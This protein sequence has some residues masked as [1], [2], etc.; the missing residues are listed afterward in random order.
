M[1]KEDIMAA[2]WSD[3]LR[4]AISDPD[5]VNAF[6]RDTGRKLFA[7]RSAMDALID[8]ATGRENDDIMAFMVWATRTQWGWDEAPASFRIDADKWE[9]EHPVEQPKS[10]I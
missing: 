4:Y 2:A 5:I 1:T 7:A 8:K 6:S 10:S 9:R 3:F